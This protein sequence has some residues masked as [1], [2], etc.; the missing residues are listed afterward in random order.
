[1]QRVQCLTNKQRLITAN[2]AYQLDN[3]DFF[4]MVFNGPYIGDVDNIYRPWMA[5]GWLDWSSSADNT[6]F[7]YLVAPR[8]SALADYTR[9]DKSMFRCPADVYLSPVQRQRGWAS[10]IRSISADPLV[11]RGNFWDETLGPL[12]G[13][14]NL[15]IYKG[16]AKS[17]DLLIPTPARTWVYMDE[18]PDSIND[19]TGLPPNQADNMP[20][21]PATYHNCAAG[22]AMADGHT[23][24][25]HWKGGKMTRPRTRDTL[26]EVGLL[27][28]NFNNQN[29]F[30]VQKGDPD[31]YWFSYATPRWS[32]KTV[33]D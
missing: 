4:P 33:A 9:G 28:V 22:F 10:R 6:N 30:S 3:H 1:V 13:H 7:V 32:E 29:N 23:E 18:H 16:A 31:L 11:G 2:S 12:K 17:T 21:G 20:D 8:F 14:G 24:M 25:H 15:S 27:G 19:P 5:N 26:V